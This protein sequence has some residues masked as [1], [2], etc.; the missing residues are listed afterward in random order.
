MKV[1]TIGIDRRKVRPRLTRAFRG[2]TYAV[3]IDLA[4]FHRLADERLR[5]AI[6]AGAQ[7]LLSLW[8]GA[9]PAF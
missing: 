4:P 5:T 3:L 7:R 8:S 6:G 1:K 2:R 9:C